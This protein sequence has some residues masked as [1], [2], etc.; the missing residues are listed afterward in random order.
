M[1][2]RTY[3]S[4]QFS[5]EIS[6]EQA[7]E[8]VVLLCAQ[9]CSSNA[10]DGPPTVSG[11]KEHEGDSFYDNECNYATMAEIEAWCAENRVSYLKDWS[12]GGEY[13]PGLELYDHAA[14]TTEQCSAIESSPAI[15][16]SELITLREDGALDERIAHL[17]KF[18]NFST[19][20]PQLKVLAVGDWTDDLCKFMAERALCDA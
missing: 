4:I 7:G 18:E 17:S 10:T 5:G 1:G 3:T 13:G 9:G 19:H 20:F 12:Q 11:L 6:E 8:L 15:T 14:G 2:D 16:L